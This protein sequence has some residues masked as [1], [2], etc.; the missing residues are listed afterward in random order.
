M[1]G[2]GV[3]SEDIALRVDKPNLAEIAV[4]AHELKA[5][6]AVI[7]QLA[8][9]LGDASLS[10]NERQTIAR[11]IEL[12]ASRSLRFTGNIT[13][14]EQLALS[15][16]DPINSMQVCDEVI[17]ELRPLYVAHERT[18]RFRSSR[19]PSLIVANYDLLRR[20]LL[21]FGDNAL[22]YGDENG[23]VEFFVELKRTRQMMRIGVR[24]YGPMIPA[25]MWRRVLNTG[26]PHS[27][28]ARPE[29]SGLGL[30][31]VSQFAEAIGG[32]IGAIRHRNGASFYVELPISKQL[33]LL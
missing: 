8:L 12:I 33:T 2:E 26:V 28:S 4:A 21:N 1:V 19:R 6:L 9:E 14:T 23:V 13:K 22:H 24:D 18:I 3:K 5:P 29:S 17:R 16:T 31:I 27:V 32:Q 25:D 30:R 7:R 15:E 20:I 10:E 11:Q